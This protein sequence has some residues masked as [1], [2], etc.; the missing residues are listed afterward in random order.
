MAKTEYIDL[1]PAESDLF[2]RGLTPQDR[3]THGRVTKKFIF[4]SLKRKK[5][6]TQRSLLP[7]IAEFWAGL[8]DSVKTDWSN[9]GAQCGLNGWRLFVQDMC[10][11]IKND[12][13]GVAI[14][15]LLHQSWIGN[16]KIESPDSEIKITQLHPRFY[17]TLKKVT[18][19][20]G[21]YEPIKITEDFS[22][23]LKI[24]LNYS[25]NLVSQ[26]AGSFA[27]YYASVWR[28]YQGVDHAELLEIPLDLQTGWK[29][30]EATL[31]SVIGQIIGYSLYF[32]LYNVT[33][34]LYIDNVKAEHSGQNWVRDTYCKDILQG[35]TKAF[36]QI[37]KHWVGVIV[38]AGVQYDSI[39]KDF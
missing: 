17:W 8:S 21:T 31:S 28:T 7:V 3:F 22:L 39:Y 5:G 36:Y 23:P 11:R 6:L 18:G 32:H 4:Y 15:S 27:K 30:A 37:P 26:G 13:E 14:P 16:L 12:I 19:K 38:P 10:A 1:L 35:F 34:D 25:A 24:G 20:K 29:N 9:A 33:G 2:Y